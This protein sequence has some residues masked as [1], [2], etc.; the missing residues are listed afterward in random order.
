MTALQVILRPFTLY[1]LLE[2]F[3]PQG[4]ILELGCGEHSPLIGCGLSRRTVGLDIY[5]PYVERHLSDNDYLG[6][7]EA[8]ITSEAIIPFLKLYPQV[9]LIDVLEHL[10]V[11][12]GEAL[13]DRVE[14]YA[15][16][17]LI[18]TPNGY[19]ENDDPS[20]LNDNQRHLSGWKADKLR[21]R[22]YRLRG[23]N[24]LG[25]LRK[26]RA[27]SVIPGAVGEIVAASSQAIA[28]FMPEKAFH[29]LATL[30][31]RD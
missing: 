6:C 27:S 8:D 20:G 12:D 3:F 11:S 15:K 4:T 24:G 10:T 30:E 31:K 9:A 18:L 17:V 16:R 26:E 13:L 1:G 22:G 19:I 21:R 7:H 2:W 29:L 25:F 28:W 5:R 23:Y 14:R